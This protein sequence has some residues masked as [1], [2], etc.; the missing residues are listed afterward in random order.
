MKA[1]RCWL[2]SVGVSD[3]WLTSHV[4]GQ[5][6][7]SGWFPVWY[8][9]LRKQSAIDLLTESRS[10]ASR[11]GK[12]CVRGAWLMDASA[13]CLSGNYSRLHP[14]AWVSQA[15]FDLA[16]ILPTRGDVILRP[17][18]LGC[19]LPAP[20]PSPPRPLIPL[21]VPDM[22]GRPSRRVTRGYS[23]TPGAG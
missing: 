22:R 14:Q 13:R 10:Q 16:L 7:A 3:H 8:L 6:S 20:A 23:P 5:F 11:V 21:G 19:P 18:A 15:P 9:C 12:P 1:K 17:L 4:S 2:L